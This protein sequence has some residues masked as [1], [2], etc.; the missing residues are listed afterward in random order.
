LIFALFVLVAVSGCGKRKV[1]RRVPVAMVPAVPGWKEE[2][3][4]SWYGNPYH[5]RAAAN[6]E[7]YDMEKMTAAHRTLPFGA[8]VEVTNLKNGKK[9][10][11]RITDRGPFF[12]GRIID[13]SKAAAREIELIGPGTA[14]VRIEVKSYSLSPRPNGRF[15]VQVG[16]YHDKKEAERLV[17][18]LKKNF[19]P[20][21]AVQRDEA[22][23]WRV[24]V[25]DRITERD[26]ESLAEILRKQEKK[27]FVVR[28]D[29]PA[30]PET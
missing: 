9:T 16:G 13:L 18:R 30:V 2:G 4:A 28:L 7:I 15:A 22:P 6:G 12:E 23:G 17:E 27:A 25:G 1:S 20:V 10:E 8:M 3:V 26:A 19:E 11:V 29:A 5:G 21:Q 14:P 24:L